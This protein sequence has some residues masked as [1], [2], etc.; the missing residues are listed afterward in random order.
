V[1]R[2]TPGELALRLRALR[3]TAAYAA[4][5]AELAD[6]EATLA[7]L[8]DEL[9][10]IAPSGAVT[11]L[12]PHSGQQLVAD[13]GASAVE[14][15]V[16]D[17]R[18]FSPA[19]WALLDRRR[20]ALA[21]RGVV[22]FVTTPSSFSELMRHATNLASWLGDVFAVPHDDATV[23]ARREQRLTALRRWANRSDD[24]IVDAAR[25]GTLPA[26]PAYAEWLVL[27][28]HGELLGHGVT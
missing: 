26:D 1:G 27:L 19:D 8:E 18:R 22:I 21:H 11:R 15:V 25:A 5:L 6:I 7:D 16:V 3:G 4:Y 24:E 10:A 13:L 12:S 2:T 20:S 14:I 28:G 17:A 9:R 23:E